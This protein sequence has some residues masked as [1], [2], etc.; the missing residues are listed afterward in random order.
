MR[1]SKKIY[2]VGGGPAGMMAAAQ[3]ALKG[4]D[5]VLLE[6]NEKLGKKLFITGK[7]RCNVTNAC[8]ME[9]FF[10]NIAHNARFCYSALYA[11]PPD[12]T[13]E[14]IEQQGIPL[15]VERGSRVFPQS[16]KS[17]DIIKALERYV[18][19]SGVQILLNTRLEAILTAE[20]R[21]T[22]VR[23][24]GT[25]HP[26][27]GVILALG[28]A[29]YPST[30]SRGAWVGELEK[31][32]HTVEPLRPALVP[33][34][35]KEPWIRELQGLSLKNVTLSAH[36]GRRVIYEELGELLFTH[37]GLSGPL[38]LTL[39]SKLQK[40][41]FSKLTLS[42][43]LKPGL[44]PEQLDARLLRELSGAGAKALKTVCLTLLPARL[45]PPV[46]EHAGISGEKQASQVTQEERQRLARTL[47]ALPMTVSGFR[48]MEEA[49]ITRGGI[50]TKEIDPSTM[51]SKLV[52]G[53]S[54]AGEMVDIDGFTGG[55]NIQLALSTG[56]LA[57]SSIE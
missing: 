13:R 57:G 1:E 49:I 23:Y 17:S 48:P 41:D 22:G 2:V 42:L 11:F 37:F 25:A 53:L 43:D 45:V 51:A 54:F 9:D 12:Q 21:V 29:S 30:G 36:D 40:P 31:L 33:L 6:Q 4:Y 35:S 39:S 55:F 18:R 8:D 14:L 16:D 19:A 7:G 27:D 50:S 3:C 34:E 32:G 10:E 28:G 47:K 52:S 44:T 26:C 20:N 38:V 15:K 24:H 46:L 56:Y 5:T